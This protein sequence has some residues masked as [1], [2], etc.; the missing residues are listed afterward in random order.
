MR[1]FKNPEGQIFSEDSLR[2]QYGFD[3]EQAVELFS[4]EEIFDDEEETFDNGDNLYITPNGMEV[5]EAVLIEEY[6][7]DK[8]NEFVS[9]GSLKKKGKSAQNNNQN[10][11]V[12]SQSELE[13]S[14]SDTANANFSEP[15]IEQDYFTGAF[16]DAL[17]AFDSVSPIGIGDF[18]DDMAR[19]VA[20]GVNQGIAGENASDL[21]M[22]GSMSSE[23]DIQSYL[24]AQK[25][26]EKYGPSA[27]MQEY[28]KI[29]EENGKGFLG[30]VLGI[31]NS[32][33]TILPELIISSMASM[34]ANTDSLI[35][36]GAAVATGAGYGA[37]TGVAAGGVGAA[38]GA[39]AGAVAAIPY[40][41]A[42]AG[43][44]LEMGATFAELLKEEAGDQEL[45]AEK[46][47]EILNDPEKYTRIRNKAVTRGIV[48][49]AIDAF[50]GKLGGKIGSK[51][52]TKGGKTSISAASKTRKLG[53]IAT[54]SGI[55]GAG[56]SIGEASA[57]LAIGQDMDISEIA[58]EGLAE[59]PGGVRD[60]IS[61][62][63]SK[64][65]Y[66]VNGERVSAETIDALVETMTL[67]Q[68]T[69]S[70]II[71][72][73]D[74]QGRGKKLQDRIKFLSINRKISEVNGDLNKPTLDA[75]TG[76][77]VEL[78]NL[79]GNKTEIAKEKSNAI[80]QQIKELQDNP[81][82]DTTVDP[83]LQGKSDT[84]I[85]SEFNA[86][87]YDE[88]MLYIEK[89][90]DYVG[91]LKIFSDE[92]KSLESNQRFSL[93]EGE[94]EGEALF[95]S[96]EEDQAAIAEEMANFPAE[97]LEFTVPNANSEQVMVSPIEESNTIV[98]F[99]DED[100]IEMGAKNKED[101]VKKIEF[102]NGIPMITGVSDTASGGTVFDSVG[103]KMKTGGGIMFNAIAKIKAAWA[104]VSPDV[105]KG[106]Y[107]NAV[108]TY[109]ANKDLFDRLWKEKKLPDGHIPMAI[110][111]M[112]NEAINSNEIVFRYLSPEV[113]AQPIENQIAAMNDIIA[114]LE[115]KKQTQVLKFI[116]DNNIK[117]LGVFLD[118]IVKD[119]KERAQSKTKE[120]ADKHLSLNVRALIFKQLAAIE[121]KKKP[122]QKLFLDSLYQGVTDN[123]SKFKS[124]NIYK[125]VAEPS[126]MKSKK[127]DIVS[128][129]GVDVKNGG[130][131]DIDHP[132]Y[133]TGPKG[134]LIALISNPTNGLNLFPAWRA[135]SSRIFT[136]NVKGEYPS[137]KSTSAQTMGTGA[138]DTTFQGAVMDTEMTDIQ[139]ISAKMRFAFPGVSVSTSIEEFNKQ[140]SKPGTRTKE[141]E[142]KVILGFAQDGKIYL[143]PE[144]A[145]LSTPIHEFGHIW[146]DFLRSKSSGK[147]GSELIAKGLKLVEGTNY[148]KEAIE[149]YGDTELA[150]EEALVE[151]IA[152]KG[153]N[154]IKAGKR[155]DSKFKDWMNAVFKYIKEKF[156]T[157][158]NLFRIE[159]IKEIDA[160]IKNKLKELK[161]KKDSLSPE[162]YKVLEDKIKT[163][164]DRDT[165]KINKS[166]DSNIN[167]MSLEE[168]IN[169]G[170]ADLLGGNLL[171]KTF[172][173]KEASK[174][175]AR[176]SL[177]ST[178][179]D[180]ITKEQQN[181]KIE[182]ERKGKTAGGN[183]LFNDEQLQDAT[184]IAN[185]ISKRTG[186][187]YT[188]AERIVK[189]NK[190]R[191]K[192]ISDAY[193]KAKSEPDNK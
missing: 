173:A 136:P 54:A 128:I 180:I 3:F 189:L 84:E 121:G 162:E 65:K 26:A 43:T 125:A 2:Q 11:E 6:G 154:I 161:E 91:G 90:N 49:G 156:I 79:E 127:G 129:V 142:G 101:L 5:E 42:A 59:I 164:S 9:Q 45:T 183:K 89:G 122:D 133:G 74:Y 108:K 67:E 175:G 10:R 176:N 166:I 107:S 93:E 167:S 145:T 36:A 61:T 157:S 132:N 20:G 135:K 126:M 97:E 70:K 94:A 110:I 14:E 186:I 87:E 143:N 23:E 51:V 81:L 174:E 4:F 155:E 39:V 31:A 24:D 182:N 100:A 27:E 113:K 138:N 184:K 179:S 13:S 139:L 116:K 163:K 168:F 44:A 146:V 105:S 34:A 193:D 64:P 7:N 78:D 40:A 191:A 53:A 82:P 30:V 58:L 86:L 38:P 148:L 96:N 134:Q 18:I 99:T 104:G 68:L 117:D 75:L 25:T 153:L 73:N 102:F 95:L 172:D 98:P 69:Q 12:F 124:E 77:Q 72:D 46:I 28:Q 35:A 160:I 80:R 85:E 131:I 151:M 29:Y 181:K 130:V 185:R 165:K 169:V 52:L 83:I 111:R 141:S 62:R 170:L 76:L 22:N 106:Q 158:N 63:F 16:G 21:L 187:D 56:G 123:R 144:A 50:T 19:A 137:G 71:I 171:S 47:K 15:I 152:N 37:A 60:V 192:R 55:E 149:I 92:I 120:E 41:F 112:G 1:K 114:G 177:G 178:L 32:G 109:E 88:Q 118:S 190:E 33:V 147:R 150:R 17:R 8:F 188:N 48:I 103:N 159:Q 115:S 140:I 57:R 119:A 66:K